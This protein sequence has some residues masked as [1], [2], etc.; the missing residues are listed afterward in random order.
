[1][2]VGNIEEI[3]RLI[4]A[5]AAERLPVCQRDREKFQPAADDPVFFH[6]HAQRAESESEIIAQA[7]GSIPR[8]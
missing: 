3:F 1:M 2:R 7:S 8:M 4:G 5:H 6:L